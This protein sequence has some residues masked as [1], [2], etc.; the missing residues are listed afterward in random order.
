MKSERASAVRP[1]ICGVIAAL[2]VPMAGKFILD[3][4]LFN[5]SVY[6]GGQGCQATRVVIGGVEF[7]PPLATASLMGDE[8]PVLVIHGRSRS[9]ALLD[10]TKN[11]AYLNL[12]CQTGVLTGSQLRGITEV[13][14][15]A[16]E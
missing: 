14:A 13:A 5:V 4:M 15:A 6:F 9:T 12:D 7:A 16:A 10:L 8:H 2:V 11:E 3:D 1:F